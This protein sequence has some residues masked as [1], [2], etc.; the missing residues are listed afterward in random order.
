MEWNSSSVIEQGGHSYCRY[1]MQTCFVINLACRTSPS[2]AL[3]RKLLERSIHQY[4]AQQAASTKA[5]ATAC[6]M[7]SPTVFKHCTGEIKTLRTALHKK[8]S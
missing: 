7:G 6:D 3:W 8:T 2:A 4:N 1:P 5:Y